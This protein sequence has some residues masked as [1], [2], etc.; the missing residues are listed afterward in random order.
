MGSSDHGHAIMAQS[1]A[2]KHLFVQILDFPIHIYSALANAH[3]GFFFSPLANSFPHPNAISIH[4][5]VSVHTVTYKVTFAGARV[6]TT[7]GHLMKRWRSNLCLE[8]QGQSIF[9]VCFFQDCLEIT[10]APA[11][12]KGGDG[13][14]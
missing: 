14:W 12:K 4:T 1:T 7:M 3:V 9:L 2:G 13:L 8:Y 10:L 11:A 6:K 5:K